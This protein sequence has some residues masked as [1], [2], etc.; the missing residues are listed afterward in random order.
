M[1]GVL[2]IIEGRGNVGSIDRSGILEKAHSVG[3]VPLNVRGVFGP[4]ICD[5]IRN[6]LRDDI[7]TTGISNRILQNGQLQTI[8]SILTW[9]SC[10]SIHAKCNHSDSIVGRPREIDGV[11]QRSIIKSTIPRGAPQNRFSKVYHCI[12]YFNTLACANCQIGASIRF[13]VDACSSI[14]RERHFISYRN[15]AWIFR[16]SL[17]L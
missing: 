9:W 3:G 13:D 6:A 5:F 7:V 10:K 15:L 16:Q 14:N 1:N 2:I 8:S 4:R 11:L 12:C 17:Q